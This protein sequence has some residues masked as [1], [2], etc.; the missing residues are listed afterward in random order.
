[1]ETN[2]VTTGLVVLRASRLEALVAPLQRLLEVTRPAHPLAPQRVV[3]A[4]PAMKAWLAAALAHEVG[5]GRIVANLQVQLPSAWID[6][7]SSRLLG[8]RAVS[9]PRYRRG[10]LRWTV[11]ALLGDPAAHGVVDARLRAYLKPERADDGGRHADRRRFQLAD[12]LAA[13][14]SQYLVYRRDWLAAWEAGVRT[15][16]TGRQRDPALR[17]L[18]AEGLAP[19]WRAVA[20]ALGPHRGTLV[21]ALVEAIGRP[22]AAF[23]PLHVFG[24][25]H[26][27][28]AELA[29]LR[30]YA[31][32]AP[33]FAYVPDPCREFW[34]GLFRAEPQGPWR[35]PDV[36]GWR[37]YLADERSRLDDPQGIDWREQGHPLL[38]RWGRLGQHFLATLVD[39]GVREDIR[40][41]DD[42]SEAPCANRLQRLQESV[43]RLDPAL[44]RED[45]ADPRGRADAS[46]R[47]H[48]CHNRLRELEVLRDALLDAT[49]DGATA[50]GG[51]VVMAPDIRAYLPLIPAVF[52]EPGSAR[53][54]RLPYHLADVPSSR[55]HPL[56]GAFRTLLGVGQSRLTAADA[57]DLLGFDAV[58][59]ALRLTTA[60]SDG[61]AGWLRESRVAWGLDGSHKASIGLP[62]RAEHTFAWAM[63]RMIAGYVAG[64]GAAGDATDVATPDAVALQLADGAAVLPVAGIRGPG[65]AA[66][67][68]LDRLLTELQSWRDLAAARLAASAW[69]D[70]LRAR[71]DALLA[72]DA[73]DVEAQAALA[74]VHRAIAQVALEP[75]ENGHDPQL[76]FDVVRDVLEQALDGSTE[77]SRFLMGGVTFCGMV[78]QR[79]LPFDVVA[80][81]GL[82]EG[83]FPRRAAHGGIDLMASLRRVGDRDAPSDDR[84]LFLETV[85]AA[86]RRLHLSY[87]GQAPRDGRARNPAAPLA[88]LLGELDRHAGLEPDA[89][90]RRPWLVKHP[91]QPF[92]PRYF[93]GAD[94]ALFSYSEAFAGMQGDGREPP[95]RLRD[96]R[97]LIPGPAPDPLPLQQLESFF[98]DPSKAILRDQFRVSLVA[99]D[100]EALPDAEPLEHLPRTAAVSRRLFLDT[101]LPRRAA[102]PAALAELAPPDWVRHGGLLPVG[103]RAVSA[104][105]E[106]SAAVEALWRAAHASARFDARA[107]SGPRT[108]AVAVDLG[109]SSNAANAGAAS[110]CGPARI[111]GAIRQVFPLAGS[112]DG[113]QV[114]RAF[115]DRA[116]GALKPAPKLS[117][118]DTVPAFLHWALLRLQHAASGNGEAR[119]IRLTMLAA[120]APR[121]A[122]QACE[123]DEAYCADSAA[124]R[125]SR[126]ADLRRRLSGLVGLWASARTGARPFH[127]RS[128]SAALS[129]HGAAHDDLE[130]WATEAAKAVREAWSGSPGKPGGER[131]DAPG[132]GRWLERDLLFGDPASDAGGEALRALLAMAADV[133][134]LLELTDAPETG[135]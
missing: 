128:A 13:V 75:A 15:A 22:D 35:A 123:W 42:G 3:A 78:P 130:A 121:L 126:E 12:R 45:P 25:S 77:R 54:R 23:E 49:A 133:Q 119:P 8:E 117:L 82:D 52:G 26:L 108:E 129:V 98:R 27:P 2:D 41:G 28:P 83:A 132:Y 44:L 16:A 21:D 55:S 79:A 94:P 89:A 62:P 69:A 91:L 66:L 43:R 131:E 134:R 97:P 30:A 125:R 99:L 64:D 58:Q 74:V 102:D 93:D 88:E 124:G 104:W 70:A 106:E 81:L 96:G 80:V 67:G 9:L 10:P 92:D 11:H 24:L 29:V 86:R 120:G 127:P 111:V 61:L 109:G 47:V 135:E 57:L 4:H 115:P 84:Y 95:P 114:V 37:A 50:P 53:E 18:E 31:A 20:K 60:E 63:D 51:I 68:A 90:G 76:G 40:D 33:V 39:D 14:F 46:L 85:M 19:L 65:A 17:A 110:T 87:V 59:R 36:A 116:N 34:G 113:L 5:P 100:D 56:L 73:E 1:M 6:G 118:R 101:V 107:A 105:A 71:V 38:A 32:R 122:Q 112:T 48:A 7:L 72:V 103:R